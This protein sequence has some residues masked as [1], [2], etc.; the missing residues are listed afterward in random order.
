MEQ[1]P[2]RVNRSLT[3]EYSFYLQAVGLRLFPGSAVEA[4]LPSGMGSKMGSFQWTFVEYKE[5]N[6][7]V[8]AILLLVGTGAKLDDGSTLAAEPGIS[9]Q[10]R[11]PSR[12]L[13]TFKETSEIRNPLP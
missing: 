13:A 5:P 3:I 10:F 4:A 9:R 2:E 6:G 1:T 12:A 11:E 8:L 7:F